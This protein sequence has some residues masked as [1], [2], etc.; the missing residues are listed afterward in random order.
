[1]RRS[2]PLR[3]TLLLISASLILFGGIV[4]QSSIL[5]PPVIK[6]VGRVRVDFAQPGLWRS[7]NF[8]QNLRF[9][10]YI[11]FLDE[12]IPQTAPVVLPGREY[13]PWAGTTTPFMQFFLA[14]RPV[15]NCVQ[16]PTACLAEFSTAHAYFLLF[17]PHPVR[18]TSSGL[19]PDRLRM[20]DRDWG[21]YVPADADYNGVS[22]LP[23]FKSL[24][25]ILRSIA[26]PVLWL[27]LLLASGYIVCELFIPSS[28][29]TS[30]MAVAYGLATGLVS[31]SLFFC[32]LAG[33]RLSSLLILF[34]SVFWFFLSLLVLLATKGLRI[35]NL[36][37]SKKYLYYRPS[38]DHW[39]V[40]FL[41]LGG[42]AALLAVG[43]GYH[44]TDAILLWGAKGYGIA[45]H[46]L[47]EGASQWGTGTVQYTLH[48]PILIAAFRVLFGEGLPASKLIFPLYFWSLLALVYSFLTQRIARKWAGLGTLALGTA[49]LLF[50]HATIGYAN[51][52]FAFYFIAGAFTFPEPSDFSRAARPESKRLFLSGIFF[53][54]SAWTRPEGF[55][56]SAMVIVLL[57][58]FLLA[59][60]DRPDKLKSVLALTAPL[61]VFA[62]IWAILA[63]RIYQGNVR[64]SGLIGQAISRISQ[65]NL[66]TSEAVYVLK[67]LGLEITNPNTWGIIGSGSILF[68]LVG[69]SLR[70]RPALSPL[71]LLGGLSL[72]FYLGMY[73]VTSYDS[74]QDI[75]WWVNTGLDRMIMPGIILIWTGSMSSLFGT[76]NAS[77][78]RV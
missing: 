37:D 32:L 5:L 3:S 38:I 45:T 68:M 43:K 39:Q 2:G 63:P 59:Q 36:Q 30:K 29:N 67:S 74:F 12:N 50:R 58:G 19:E 23:P 64:E 31:L 72:V 14:P 56:L 4:Y 17:D 6:D 51:A 71:L 11:K 28:R 9:A 77:D 78:H 60:D 53:L 7:A 69:I 20:F 24:T 33:M 65:G 21:L 61:A 16:P 76:Q 73:Y 10:N 25:E 15:S 8:S 22:S 49:P 27:I 40:L 57:S 62:V 70:G 46:G 54:L 75:S 18:A 55:I 52:A 42:L 48:I 35:G 66:H 47:V 44:A 13:G 1:M 34:I 26:L 41:I